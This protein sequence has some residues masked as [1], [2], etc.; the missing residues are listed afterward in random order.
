MLS[1]IHSAA[2]VGVDAVP[3]EVEVD[4]SFGLPAFAIAGLAAT[5]EQDARERVRAAVKNSQGTVPARRILVN[6]AP[7]DI[8]KEGAGFDLPIALGLLLATGQL[9]PGALDGTMAVGEL[10][11]DGRVRPTH[12]VLPVAM[13]ARRLEV[14]RLLVPDANATEAAAAGGAVV[15]VETLRE[16][17][18]MLEGR[19]AVRPVPAPPAAGREHHEVDFA[20]IKGQAHA[21]RALVVAAAGAHHLL[22]IG[23]PGAGKTMLARRLPTILPPLGPEEALEVTKIHSVAGLISPG[24]GL[25]SVRPFRAPHHTTSRHALV[26]GGSVPRPGELSLAHHGVLFLDELPEFHRDAL[27][28]LRQPLEEG[29]VTI[30]RVQTSVTLPARVMLAAAMNPCPCGY[31]GDARRP[32]ACTP[33]QVSRYR[34]R[35]SGPLLDRFDL[36]VEVPRLAPDEVAAA[37]AGEGSAA[38]R[39]HVLAARTIQRR[40]FGR[41]RVAGNGRM[42]GR[43]MR[44][45]CLLEPAAAQLLRAATDR[46]ALSARAYDRVL[47]VARTIADLDGVDGADGITARHVAEALQYRLP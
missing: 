35:I 5:S 23:P 33:P 3:V 19:A 36:Q 18:E 6:L 2:L 39:A 32:C 16:A 22:L 11:L 13:L 21:R 17:V 37:P 8:R 26:G 47:R 38:L 42:S 46:L 12:G 28:V 10:S 1:R 24:V 43:A 4:V 27:E 45:F 40:R 44:R 30:A 34:A 14:H 9:R 7:A 29:V 31:L 15:P 41:R 20:E 25:L